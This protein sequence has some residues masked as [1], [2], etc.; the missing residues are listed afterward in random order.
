M[1]QS[2][3]TE[4]LYNLIIFAIIRCHHVADNGHTNI[5]NQRIAASRLL[6]EGHW[7]LDGCMSDVCFWCPAWVRPR[8]LCITFRFGC[9]FRLSQDLYSMFVNLC[10][11]FHFS[12]SGFFAL[13]V[14]MVIVKLL[15]TCLN[16]YTQ[17]N[18]STITTLTTTT[19]TT[20]AMK[21]A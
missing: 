13:F 21:S 16:T 5:R 15:Y 4:Q 8:Q 9:V 1:M 18:T 3:N 17:Q 20:T 10:I 12:I 2:L 6:H 14:F 11:F 7:R 19:T